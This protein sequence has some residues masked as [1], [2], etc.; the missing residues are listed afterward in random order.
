MS[1]D[2]LLARFDREQRIE[3]EYPGMK[4][5]VL[6]GVVRFLR[7][8]PGMS[9]VAFSRLD[10]RNAD[11]VI[12]EQ[13]DCFTAREGPFS[14]SAYRHDTPPDL[15]DRLAAHGF[16]PAEED[17]VMILDLRAAGDGQEP[18]S[19]A[20]IRI[21][22]DR[23]GLQDVIT[24]LEGVYE[25]DF[26]WILERMGGHLDLSGYLSIYVAYV[27]GEPACTGWTFFHGGSAFANLH[28]GATVPRLR[29]RGLYSAV[30]SARIEEA[31]E[32]GVQFLVTDASP[33]SQPILARH[34]FQVLTH[35]RDC[36]WKHPPGGKT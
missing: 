22:P 26:S 21:V 2:D 5:E 8:A 36:V 32:R 28:G 13:V 4:K 23:D 14:W 7:P 10:D 9:F 30:L 24:V 35:A 3:I 25:T 16:V 29:G 19:E 1:D 18:P 6:P 17:V 34:G 33:M 15:V 12:R 11:R 27:K 20:D 31:R